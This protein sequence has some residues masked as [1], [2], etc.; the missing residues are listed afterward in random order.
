MSQRFSDANKRNLVP[1]DTR[2]AISESKGLFY[3]DIPG[4]S[5]VEW[6]QPRKVLDIPTEA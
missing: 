4:V 2:S 3:R 5:L 1:A 6:R